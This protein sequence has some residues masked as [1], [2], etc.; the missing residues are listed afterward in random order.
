[1]L[2]FLN[3]SVFAYAIPLLLLAVGGYFLITLRAFPFTQIRKVIS[4]L[5]PKRGEGTDSVRALTLA[6]ASTLGVGNIVGVATALHA[7]GAGAVFWMWVSALFSMMLKYAETALAV[8]YRVRRT[9][10]WHGGAMYYLTARLHAPLLSTLFCL[11]CIGASFLIGNVV[12]VDAVSEALS[13]GFSIPPLAVGIVFA[14]LLACITLGGAQRVMSVTYRLIPALSVGYLLL[15]VAIIAKNAS[16]LPEVLARIVTDAFATRSV[17]GGLCGY[18]IKSAV[19]YGVARGLLSNEAGCGTAPIAHAASEDTTPVKQGCMG[20]VE[21]VVDTL[22]L[23]TATATVILLCGDA[24]Y[25]QDGITLAIGAYGTFFGRIAEQLLALAVAC[26]ALAAAVGW[27]FYATESIGYLTR[28]K[29]VKPAYLLAYSATCILAV[30]V[31][32]DA[33]WA[34]ADFFVYAMTA[35]Q[36]CALFCLRREVVAL[37]ADAFPTLFAKKRKK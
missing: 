1:M 11:L 27:S 28:Q 10:G 8:H 37:T 14:L 23:C 21:V 36:V 19:R 6:L 9:D 24:F 22:L 2:S 15:S 4:Y 16:A 18:G 25:R 31:K 5:L 26:F 33:I 34:W 30:Y 20:I 12:Q 3:D 7:G 35:L 17:F 13:Y 29:W 32:N